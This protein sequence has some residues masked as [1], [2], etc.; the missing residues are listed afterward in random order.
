M[1]VL[2]TALEDL[3]SYIYMFLNSF[4]PIQDKLLLKLTVY[5]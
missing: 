3:K 5:K 2:R 1:L 4:F